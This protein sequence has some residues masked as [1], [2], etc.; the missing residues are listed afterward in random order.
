VRLGWSPDALHLAVD[1]RDD[2]LTEVAGKSTWLNDGVEVYFDGR[3]EA[4]RID[5][6]GELVSQNMFPALRDVGE[7]FEGNRGWSTNAISWALQTDAGGYVIEA[8]IPYKLIRGGEAPARAGDTARF[9]L[10]VN[11]RDGEEGGQSHHRLWST[12]GASSNTSG[13]GL[14]VL[15]P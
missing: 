14:V 5:A 15:S 12:T 10:M 2:T 9:D 3:P 7:T 1:V 4:E 13:Y 6:Y 11:D 8:T